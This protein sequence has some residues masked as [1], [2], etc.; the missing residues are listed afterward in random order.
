[1]KSHRIL[2]ADDH[3]IVIEGLRRILEPRFEIV[4]VAADG[5]ALVSA[6]RTLQ[7]D[8]IVVDISMPLLNGIEAVSQIRKFDSDVKII[9]LTMHSDVTYATEALAAG[10][11]AYVLKISAGEEILAAIES[12]LNG[13][14][15]VTPSINPAVARAL[16]DRQNHTSGPNAVLTNRQREVLQLLAEGKSLKEAADVLAVSVRTVEF[17]KYQIMRK[18]GLHTNAEIT[19]YAVKLG[20]T[21]L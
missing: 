1:M 18:V 13:I 16:R 21:S 19:K 11:S 14:T 6:A 3:M 15:Y 9:F 10:G 20:I 12:V 8:I 17:H 2:L 4:G 5:L 7:P